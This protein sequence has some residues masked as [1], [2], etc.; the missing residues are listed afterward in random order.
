MEK[1]GSGRPALPSGGAAGESCLR[2]AES[3]TV[4]DCDGQKGWILK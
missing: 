1:K 2:V 3:A 4:I